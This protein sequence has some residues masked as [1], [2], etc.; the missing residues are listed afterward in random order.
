MS[1][2]FA[3]PLLFTASLTLLAAAYPFP[4]GPAVDG[5]SARGEPSFLTV[6]ILKRSTLRR[7]DG[8]FHLEKALSSVAAA[9]RKYGHGLGKRAS[10]KVG[11][12]KNI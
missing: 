5:V 9:Q 6:P 3:L 10:S 11:A 4:H 8:T 1:S 12:P 7:G 2:K